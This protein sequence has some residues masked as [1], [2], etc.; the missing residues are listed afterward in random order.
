MLT[1][2]VVAT[3]GGNVSRTPPGAN[4]TPVSGTR[5]SSS[6]MVPVAMAVP[7]L[8]TPAGSTPD[9]TRVTVKVSSD[10]ARRS[11]K[12]ATVK[13]ALVVPAVTVTVPEATAV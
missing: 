4:T 3:P 5:N 11:A 1:T 9:A 2:V 6:L 12:V 8:N 10:S 13:V 7:R